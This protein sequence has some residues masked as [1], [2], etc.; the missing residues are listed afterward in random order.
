MTK[1]ED[2]ATKIATNKHDKILLEGVPRGLALRLGGC[3]CSLWV[4][5]NTL[6]FHSLEVS[7]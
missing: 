1:G 5:D 7:M 6:C 3:N 4:S 2:L